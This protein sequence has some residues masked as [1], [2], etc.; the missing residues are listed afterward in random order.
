[1]S[2]CYAL[3][4]MTPVTV[5]NPPARAF[6]FIVIGLAVGLISLPY[7]LTQHDENGG[8]LLAVW[9]V[10]GLP[11]VL[12]FVLAGLF[13]ARA[14]VVAGP[15]GLHHNGLFEK[16]HFR[17]DEVS[18][19]RVVATRHSINLIPSGTTYEM[20]LLLANG[21]QRDLPAPHAGRLG[22][23]AEFLRSARTLDDAVAVGKA[24]AARRPGT[25]TT[26]R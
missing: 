11:C 12:G 8:S 16:R 4:P 20:R 23:R 2:D 7:F 13:S 1:M 19:I 10:L 21:K 6:R 3:R 14:V 15:D 22:G 25:T 18:S 26:S 9:L 24:L 5:R 17:W